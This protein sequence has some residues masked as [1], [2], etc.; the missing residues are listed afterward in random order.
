MVDWH[1][2]HSVMLMLV[3]RNLIEV[4][5]HLAFSA[6]YAFWTSVALEIRPSFP[7]PGPGL[8][9]PGKSNSFPLSEQS[10]Y[11]G[12]SNTSFR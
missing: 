3:A 7:R 4:P 5:D 8:M 9:V 6:A 1:C 11:E 2:L 10:L 12:G